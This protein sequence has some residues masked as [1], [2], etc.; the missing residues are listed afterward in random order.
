MKNHNSHILSGGNSDGSATTTELD[1]VTLHKEFVRLGRERHKLTYKL[2]AI[3]PKIYKLEIYKKYNFSS[4]YEYASKFAGIQCSIVDKTLQLNKNLRGKPHLQKAVESEGIHKVAL[5]AKLATPASDAAFAD[6]VK[7]IRKQSLEEFAREIRAKKKIGNSGANDMTFFSSSCHTA[8][9]QDVPFTSLC[10]AAPSTIKIEL[11]DEMQFLF[12]KLKKKYG[13]H[14]SNKE[15]LRKILKETQNS[16]SQKFSRG[17]IKK[18][19][20][21]GVNRQQKTAKKALDRKAVAQ[22]A[23]TRYIPAHQKK[24]ALQRSAG[25]CAYPGC[26]KPADHFHHTKRF[27]ETRDHRSITPL[28]KTHHE[29]AHNGLIG[30][31]E[32]ATHKW[33]LNVEAGVNSYADA[34]FRACR[35]E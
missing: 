6:K 15:V 20:S 22:K 30:N 24:A 25:K 9:N 26:L 28:C 4:I 16:H 29:F 8:P 27:S 14:L 18:E 35:R 21:T 5:V 17:E 12:L 31:E 13:N 7:N 23:H 3:L 11:D 34:Q 1:V 19:I 33:L 2:L 32:M 10:H